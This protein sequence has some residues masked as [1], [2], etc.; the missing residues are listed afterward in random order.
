M[1]GTAGVLDAF[2]VH[3]NLID[4][5]RRFTEGFVEILDTRI[6]ESVAEQTAD[7]AQ[8]PD[9]WLS[10]NPSFRTGGSVDEL[11]SARS[12][13]P[14]AAEIFRIGKDKT[15]P[16]PRPIVFHQHQ[17]DAI[18][19]ASTGDSYVLTTGTGSGKS[20]AY[21]VPIVDHVLRRGSGRGVQAIV[22]YPM[23]AL[24]NSQQEELSKF[25][26]DGFGEGGE[27]VTFARYT[28]QESP[29]ERAAILANPPD[30]LLTNYVMLEYV[31][32]R[33][34]ERDRLITAAQGLKFL[35]LDELHTYRG[36]QGADVAMLVRRVRE[37]TGAGD[38]LQCVGTSATMSTAE[39]VAEQR[40][41]VAEVAT[42]IFG[43]HVEPERVIT[44]TL[45][46]ATLDRLQV[47]ETL[48]AAVDA[49]GEAEALDPALAGGYRRLASDALA[50][51]IED[52][53]GLRAE[54]GTGILVRTPPVTVEGAAR[55]LAKITG[56]D[57]KACETA[58]RATLLAGSRTRDERTGRPLFAFRLHQFISKGASVYVTAE[59]EATREIA[60][61]Y[62]IYAPGAETE[63]RLYPL[64]FCRECGQ[65]Y[66]MVRYD[67][68]KG[69]FTARTRISLEPNGDDVRDGYLF[70]DTLDPWP[71]DPIDR[72]PDSWLEETSSGTR[73]RK[74]RRER[75]PRPFHVAPDGTAT[76]LPGEIPAAGGAQASWIAGGLMF[77]LRCGVS[78]NQ[79]RTSE[80][81]KVAALDVE[82]RSSAM[83]VLSTSIIRSLDAE[84]DLPDEV[85][86]LLTFVD[87]RQD[88]S[89]QAGHVNDF[90]LVGQLRAALYA[91][92]KHAGSEGLDPL[93]LGNVLPTYLNLA[94][95][96]YAQKPGGFDTSQADAALR[97]VVTFRAMQDLRRGWRVTLP[98]LEQTGLMRVHYPIA[99]RLCEAEDYWTNAHPLLKALNPEQRYEVVEVLMDEFRRV[100][101]LDTDV[102]SQE[103]VERLQ[104]LSREHLTGIWTVGD[105]ESV[106][107]LGIATLAAQGQGS[108]RN[109]L[110]LTAKGS[111]GRWLKTKVAPGGPL[112]D[113]ETTDV[114][115]SLVTLL[116][117]NGML[118]KARERDLHGYRLKVHQIRLFE[119]D[120]EHGAPDPVRRSHA[121]EK[122]PRVVPFFRDLY[123]DAG[124][125]LAGLVAR[126]HTA[127][128]R[129]EVRQEREKQ[130]RSGELKLLYCSPTMELGVDIASLNTVAM[131]NVPP[132]PA[133]YAQRSGRAGRS[134]Q[135]AVVVTYCASGN[136]HDSYYFARSDQMVAGRVLPPRIDL[137]NEDLVRSHVHS[138]WLACT[139]ATLGKSMKEVVDVGQP[140]YPLDVELKAAFTD[141]GLPARALAA[142]RAVLEP[143][144]H[145]L[146]D[147][148]WWSP[149]WVDD[150]IKSAPEAFDRACNRWRV[151][152]RTVRQEMDTAYRQMTDV[153]LPKKD[154]L[155][156]E[157]RQREAGRQRDLLLNESDTF[158]QG[159]YYPYRYFASE[160]FL[161]GYSFPRLPL[162]AYVPGIRGSGATWLQ[163]PRF[164]ALR[165]FGPN[166]LVYHEGARYQVTRVNLPRDP[167]GDAASTG[168]AGSVTLSSVRI[169]R[170][171]SYH[172]ERQVGTDVCENCGALLTDALD[173]LMLMQTVVTQRRDRI[174]A[175]EEERQRLGFAMVTTYRFQP[176]GTA[177]ASIHAAAVEAGVPVLDLHYGDAAELRVTNTGPRKRAAGTTPGFWI[178]TVKGKWLSDKRA[179]ELDQPEVDEDGETLLAEDVERKAR[180]VPYVEDRRNIAV[181]RWAQPVGDDEALTL[182]YAIERGVE[183]A[184]QLEDSE[185]TSELLF[186]GDGRGRFLLVEA[187]EGGAG[188]LRRLHAESGALAHVA[189]KALEI[190]HVDP[191][192]GIDDDQAC[193]AGCYRCLL[194]YGNQTDHESIDRRQAVATLRRLARAE[195]TADPVPD[196]A[197]SGTRTDAAVE[198]HVKHA[199][200][201]YSG[202]AAELL[203]ILGQR[204][205]R[206]P[207]A[208]DDEVD[209]LIVDLYYRDQ[210]AVVVFDVQ[211]EDPVDTSSL[212]FGG[213]HVIQVPPDAELGKIIDDNPSTFGSDH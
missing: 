22:V 34:K 8:W 71:S 102:F 209:G 132:T 18:E 81:S 140:G 38:A 72:I 150:V 182:M 158:G 156:A 51:W 169:C 40:R 107:Y 167:N 42:R 187:S 114:L 115:V 63:R 96:H 103:N 128:V 11:V 191:D 7:G 46:R 190:I 108:P 135:P 77:C 185:L 83:T 125:Q 143:L 48:A 49:R 30:I 189:R 23:N 89:L 170:S 76:P 193:V 53:F 14:K 36:R 43:S 174:S 175:D 200:T 44:E 204:N 59:A 122:A 10:L 87:N 118:T 58:I 163:R 144:E 9:P 15:P 116:A 194:T 73:V 82:G 17:K 207:T 105:R 152:D 52:A 197:P 206:L 93:E 19:A 69:V 199:F 188:V 142:A 100:L 112:S 121:P 196:D 208:V 64:A 57:S 181:L 80:I 111:Y 201:P 31:L 136:A 147:S 145:E 138:I 213:F 78:Y 66:L 32:V 16:V 29:D 62:Q 212:V 141:A 195:T 137:A 35:V 98:N 41:E 176:R 88:A 179:A 4:D 56:R 84:Q 85:R 67:T 91:A 146:I 131:R 149:T 177:R 183:A 20:L 210:N 28:G 24:A 173:N 120:G 25:L 2:K 119:S 74:A 117:D 75:V 110:S 133:N 172:H 39:T 27:P 160:G 50:S 202:R 5:Y 55:D 155:N 1:V 184:Y 104:A 211:G 178:D 127:Q 161:P 99:R 186:D 180:V 154:R 92:A 26:R 162:A 12:L 198:A 97:R 65:E 90:A 60:H 101:A 95:K 109:A 3:R 166:A 205:L 151:L 157:M 123:R 130:F 37:A 171:C 70:V 45:E 159:D 61:E 86:K 164:L 94:K 168:N 134:G 124:S 13:H 129:A 126:E 153:S 165:E 192:A 113:V 106:P 33:P 47:P 68:K 21:I 148:R 203:Q 139:P 6:R 54:E 79:P